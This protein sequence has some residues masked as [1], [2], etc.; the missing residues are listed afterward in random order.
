MKY[1]QKKGEPP[2]LTDWKQQANADWTP[3][4]QELRGSLK[5]SVK[6]ALMAEQGYLCCYCEQALDAVNSHIE[7]F[8]PQS[9]PT[10][11]SLDFSNLL[12]SCQ[13]QMCKGEPRH[14]G[15]LKG[16]WF[17]EVLLLS[18]LDK[19]S[20]ARFKFTADG[21]IQ[22]QDNQDTAARVTIEK[23]GI[24]IPKLRAARKLVIEIFLDGELSIGEL[25]L[26]IE[27]YLKERE[28]SHLNPFWTTINS[29]FGDFSD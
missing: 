12:C 13:N 7:H 1:I 10:V 22:P 18:P 28:D 9:D 11:D 16:D 19:N 17:D 25:S 2:E 3:S 14:C 21:H 20:E 15:N 24:N 6:K 26:F 5:Q 8:R 23:S 4:Y 29:L 27:N